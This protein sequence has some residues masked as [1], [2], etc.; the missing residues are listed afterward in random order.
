MNNYECPANSSRSP[1]PRG[2]HHCGRIDRPAGRHRDSPLRQSL[3]QLANQRWPQQPAV[4]SIPD[5][6]MG[7]GNEQ[8][9]A[10]R[11]HRSRRDALYEKHAALSRRR[12]DFCRQLHADRCFN[13]SP[14][15][16]GTAHTS[17]D[18][19]SANPRGLLQPASLVFSTVHV[20]QWGCIV[21]IHR[22]ALLGFSNN[23]P[24]SHSAQDQSQPPTRIAIARCRRARRIRQ[25]FARLPLTIARFA[26]VQRPKW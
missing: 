1:Y 26:A 18:E 9:T 10:I 14:L 17:S 23:P 7:D 3:R 11:C 8:R 4:D 19:L 21:P 22:K 25:T 12:D 16:E 5:P 2:N 20:D 13:R 6:A 24:N 15:P